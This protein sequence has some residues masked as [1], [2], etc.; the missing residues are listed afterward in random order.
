R[1]ARRA[2]RHL[3]SVLRPNA[4][5]HG[6]LGG[7]PRLVVVL[8]AAACGGSQRAPL[9]GAG[10]SNDDGGGELARMSAHLVLGADDTSVEASVGRVREYGGDDYG[11]AM[12]GGDPYGGDPYGGA[13]Y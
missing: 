1:C 12:Y 5:R 7:M 8:V 6:I 11:G 2:R 9:A 10:S 13:A 4:V 3:R